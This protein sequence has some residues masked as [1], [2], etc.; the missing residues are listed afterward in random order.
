MAKLTS[1]ALAAKLA[2]KVIDSNITIDAVI[3]SHLRTTEP[4]NNSVADPAF[5]QELL[6]GV[7]RWYG[8]LDYIATLLL[9]SAIRK[10]DRIVHFVLL[11]GLY[12]LRHLGT[13]EHAAVN[14]AVEACQQ[15]K[16]GW[17]KGLVNGCLRSYLRLQKE[18]QI[19]KRIAEKFGNSAS[20]SHPEWLTQL[21]TSSWPEH[22]QAIL[23]ANNQRPP[24]CLRVNGMRASA[25]AYLETLAEYDIAASADPYSSDGVRLD[26]PQPVAQLPGFSSGD[27][28]VQD[29]AAQIVVDLLDIQPNHKV[30]DACAAPGGKSAH[31][32]ERTHNQIELTALD[33]SSKR[34]E[35][36]RNTFERLQ[37][38]ADVQIGDASDTTSWRASQTGYDR[39]L[40]DAPCSGLGV[41]R[42]H[43]DIRYHRG[44][45]QIDSVVKTQT[46]ILDSL[47]SLLK[48]SGL[49][50][51]VT[52]SIVPAE[53]EQQIE[54][55]LLDH[56]NAKTE[57]LEAINALKLNL[58]YQSLPGVHDMDGFYYCLLRKIPAQ[59]D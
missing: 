24:M 16:K 3:E 9:K 55:F 59:K 2:H 50:L 20:A 51:Y 27:V 41:I 29:S 14:E 47:W 12:Q 46:E 13:A 49:L 54:R 4:T 42:R 38:K 11:N 40:V 6:Y 8:E 5:T 10:K 32:L 7:C 1:R 22:A 43:P 18:G 39:I 44:L 21:I 33:I 34:C 25:A 48:E 31:L 30:L 57:P 15:L 52:C 45:D 35:Q 53:N 23:N 26:K 58:G 37:L 36:L 56:E 17:A 28:S 19:D